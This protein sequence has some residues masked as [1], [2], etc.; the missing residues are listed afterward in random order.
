MPWR[1]NGLKRLLVASLIAL[2]VAMVGAPLAAASSSGATVA[3]QGIDARRAPK[4]AVIVGPVAGITNSYRAMAKDAARVARR[5]TPNVV[6]VYSPNATW[7]RVAEAIDGASIVIY[8]GHGNGWP[9]RYRDSL[10]PITQNGFGLNPVAGVDDVAHQY[11]G[12]AS[13]DNVKL[14]PNAVVLLHHLCYASGNTEPGLAEGTLDQAVQRVDNYAAGFIRAGA[15]AVVAEGH[16][17]PAWYVQQ[18]LTSN[19]SVE[20]IWRNSPSRN[21]HEQSF[22]STRSNGYRLRLDPERQQS[23]FYRSLVTK[24]TVKAPTVRANGTPVA[25]AMALPQ[26]PSLVDLGLSFKTPSFTK[27][28]IAGMSADLSLPVADGKSS[29]LP[30]DLRIG[31]RWDPIDIADAPAALPT[32]EGTAI[33]VPAGGPAATGTLTPGAPSALLPGAQQGN[34]EPP[35]IQSV[36]AERPGSVV[37]AIQARFTKTRAAVQVTF[38]TTPGLYRLVPSLHLADGSAYDAASQDLLTPVLVRVAGP[39]SAAFGVTTNLQVPAGQA[40]ELPIRV[41]N[42]GITGWTTVLDAPN[43]ASSD[44][45]DRQSRRVLSAHVIGSWISS[46]GSKVPAAAQGTIDETTA[47]PGGTGVVTLRGQAPDKTGSYLLLVDVVTAEFGAISATGSSPALIRVTVVDA[48]APTPAPTD[49]PILEP[50]S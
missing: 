26:T 33:T 9:S 8:L 37:E 41:A 44:D 5:Y 42:T 36:A 35:D 32:S 12:E 1:G 10:Y 31:V 21:G 49:S 24:G 27:L 48:P 40:F 6:E 18:L 3:A 13:L 15:R 11:F 45:A 17:E 7:P 16:F 23:R 30:D 46:T 2:I 39:L 20:S 22:D 43:L 29:L 34:I 4:V 19:R 14:A 50:G 47:L 28:P 25:T 38:P